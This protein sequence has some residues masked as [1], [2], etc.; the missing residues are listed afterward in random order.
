MLTLALYFVNNVRL[1]VKFSEDTD[2]FEKSRLNRQVNPSNA[3]G[4]KNEPADNSRVHEVHDE[5]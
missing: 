4:H 3:Q 1:T 5:L 2:D